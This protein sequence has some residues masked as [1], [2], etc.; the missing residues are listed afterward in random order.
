M[1]ISSLS[2]QHFR[3]YDALELTFGDQGRQFFYGDNGSGKTN[4]VEA[5]SLLSQGRSCLK[6]DLQDVV[7]FGDMF[8][9]V[10]A[11]IQSDHQESRSVEC[12]FQ[13]TPKRASAYFIQDVRTPLLAFI[14]TIPTIIFLPQDLDLFTGSPS[15]RRNFLDS[16][17][18]QLKPDYAALRLDYERVLKQRNVLLKRIA[19]GESKESELDV[20][21]NELASTGALIMSRRSDAL[22]A[23]SELLPAE[24]ER[25]A[26]PR[27]G[28]SIIPVCTA[29][30]DD[31]KQAL[32][33]SLRKY[34][35]RDV[36]L[37]TTTTGPH[38]DDWRIEDQGKDISV[39]ASRG[40]Q[41]S[42]LLAMLFVNAALFKTIRNERPVILLD[43]VLSEL[44]EHHQQALLSHLQDHQVIITST[45]PVAQ[46][47]DLAAWEV[48]GG[49]VMRL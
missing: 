6:A 17:L 11:Q 13:V 24:L 4:I 38:R 32:L 48:G 46:T 39:I 31:P 30:G 37:Q 23:I 12:V 21:D 35:S 44:D 36:I 15:G 47:D 20:W 41:R 14:G 45:H 49:G 25:L 40:Q 33:E 7:R 28:I 18:S 43:D 9:K 29:T 8:F 10:R 19:Q 34:R 3:S 42:I 27:T 26:E 5:V 2:L 22:L 1:R 16:L